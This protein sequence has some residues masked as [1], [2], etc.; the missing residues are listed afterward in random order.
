MDKLRRSRPP[1][2]LLRS[3]M[4]TKL[5]MMK[6]LDTPTTT[7]ESH[8][9]RLPSLRRLP[10][11]RRLRSVC[12]VRRPYS[13]RILCNKQRPLRRQIVCD[14]TRM[15]MMMNIIPMKAM[16]MIT[17]M[18]KTI[19]TIMRIMMRMKKKNMKYTPKMKEMWR[20]RK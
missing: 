11:H 10:P 19:S 2:P 15:M 18:K 14:P 16:R 1:Q 4:R 13:D 7:I 20:I 3:R 9:L 17:K 6:M 8:H 12:H 5:M